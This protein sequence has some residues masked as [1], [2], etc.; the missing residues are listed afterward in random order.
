MPLSTFFCLK[1]LRYYSGTGSSGKP[2][3]NKE[4]LFLDEV[5]TLL[6]RLLFCIMLCLTIEA[7]LGMNDGK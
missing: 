3:V 7:D 5:T 6:C 4:N 1:L 2:L